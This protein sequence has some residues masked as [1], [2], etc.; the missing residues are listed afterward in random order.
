MDRGRGEKSV[1]AERAGVQSLVLKNNS[2]YFVLNKV[3]I[4]N[5]TT[6]C[7]QT[8]KNTFKKIKGVYALLSYVHS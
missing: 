6:K 3:H 8:G 2:Q 4:V 1:Q 5:L 7:F